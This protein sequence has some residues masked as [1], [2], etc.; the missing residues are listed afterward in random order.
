MTTIE[1]A[2]ALYTQGYS[3][4]QSV[5][6]AFAESYGLNRAEALRVAAAFGGG[7]SRTGQICGAASGAIMVLGLAEAS[8]DPAD[9]ATKQRLYALGQEFLAHF[10]SRF[11]AITCPVLLGVDLT[12]PE[13]LQQARDQGLFKSICPGLVSGAVEILEELL[14][15]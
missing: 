15:S 4:S 11:G 9:K 8:L 7:I 6:G 14:A 12:T 13:G 10:Q 3:C 5:L 2:Q 1:Q